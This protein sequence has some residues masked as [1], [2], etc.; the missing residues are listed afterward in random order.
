MSNFKGFLKESVNMLTE[1]L[2]S[3]PYEVEMVKKGASDL[4]FN[5]ETEKG[6][7]YQVRFRNAPKL[8]KT[9]RRVTIRQKQGNTYKDVLKTVDEPLRVLSTVI[10]ALELFGKT[11][12]GKQTG[13][14]A[15]DFS[16][17]AMG[18]GGKLFEKIVKRNKVVKKHFTLVDTPL[19]TDQGLVTSWMVAKGQEANDVFNGEDTAGLLGDAPDTPPTHEGA[20]DATDAMNKADDIMASLITDVAGYIK[21]N[22]NVSSQWSRDSSG[23]WFRSGDIEG[24][25]FNITLESEGDFMWGV[26]LE[27]AKFGRIS[28]SSIRQLEVIN[29]WRYF[30]QIK[31]EW[32]SDVEV[33][34]DNVKID[35]GMSTLTATDNLTRKTATVDISSPRSVIA[36]D[37]AIEEIKSW[38]DPNDHLSS[39]S[40]NDVNYQELADAIKEEFFEAALSDSYTVNVEGDSIR[41]NDLDDDDLYWI[42]T[43]DGHTFSLDGEER[44]GYSVDDIVD[45][46]IDD[47]EEDE[48]AITA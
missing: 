25:N 48:D 27:G 9:V 13:G 21:F 24:Y 14:I 30:K 3:K 29:L 36:S 47:A 22:Y 46:I 11:P 18:R 45:E 2:N 38:E 4:L 39:D 31:P 44:Q 33:M 5:F 37:D 23:N 1:A 10:H 43:F 7:E 12:M 6:T 32:V 16:K 17:K 41:V 19:A 26:K 20:F 40:G 28:V 15:I 34:N 8:G 35:L 42:I